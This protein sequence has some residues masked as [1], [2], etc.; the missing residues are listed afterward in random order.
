MNTTTRIFSVLFC[1][2]L[3]LTVGSAGIFAQVE[4]ADIAAGL[5]NCFVYYDYGKVSVNLATEQSSY[6]P[7]TTAGIHGTIVNDNT[8]PLTDITLY[9]QLR[10][11]NDDTYLQNGHHLL[12]RIA[13]GKGLNFLPGETKP[14]AAG[15]PIPMGAS[16]GPYQL[17]YFIFSEKGFHYAGR[18]FLEED[19]AGSSQFNITE[20]IAPLVYF[21]ITS[22]SVNGKPHPI[23][24]ITTQYPQKE[25]TFQ[26]RIIDERQNKEDIPITVAFYSFEETREDNRVSSQRITVQKDTGIFSVSFT[27][28]AP[29]A[30]VMV[31]TMDE[32]FASELKYRF[33]KPGGSL[34][35]RI[36]D[37][38]ITA[39]P[40]T[41]S[42][43][44]YVCFH[45]PAPEKTSVTTL[46]LSVLDTTQKIVEQKSITREFS[47][48]VQAISIPLE[49]LTTP[50]DFWVKT[51]S[52]WQENGDTKTQELSTHYDCTTFKESPREVTS[53]YRAEINTLTIGATNVCGE[54]I[55]TGGYVESI[56]IKGEDGQIRKEVYNT[57]S[58]AQDISLSDLPP[59]NYTAEVVS[60]D[61]K[62]TVQF[63]VAAFS[64]TSAR[65]RYLRVLIWIVLI[66]AASVVGYKWYKRQKRMKK[67]TV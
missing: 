18:P 39:Y 58:V 33:A 23:R 67:K 42:D 24:E 65:A 36:N 2:F 14:I 8:F 13:L 27:P 31:A 34:G 6:T 10:R 5:E 47:G 40:P 41:A 21:D 28:P 56:R 1:L 45:S 49:K 4:E 62:Q 55:R 9:A 16:D 32:P 44:A 43:R 63:A 66:C 61:Q 15:V 17:Q 7:G 52:T 46:N 25:L 57:S 22:L 54:A 38:G 51:T 53:Q 35:L 30:Y 64:G 48:A 12:M 37:L 60:S 3:F 50:Q 26:A 11:V 59:G 29:G 20:S 19:F